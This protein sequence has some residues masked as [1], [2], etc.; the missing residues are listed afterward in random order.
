MIAYLV[1]AAVGMLVG[2]VAVAVRRHRRDAALVASLAPVC[3]HCRDTGAHV[4]AEIRPRVQFCN[5]CP[6]GQMYEQQAT[7]RVDWARTVR[8]SLDLPDGA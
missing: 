7:A 8:R 1:V 6:L 4:T 2:A 5:L 3:P